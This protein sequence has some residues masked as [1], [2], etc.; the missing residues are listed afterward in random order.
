MKKVSLIILL[1]LMM[2]SFQGNAQKVSTVIVKG[3][4]HAGGKFHIEVIKPDNTD[5]KTAYGKDENILVKLKKELEEWLNEGYTIESSV[6]VGATQTA[7]Y[8]I[9]YVLVKAIE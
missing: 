4:T 8:T 7:Y 6:G 9:I 2:V 1:A 3:E 5:S